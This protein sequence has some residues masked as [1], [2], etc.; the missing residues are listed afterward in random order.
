MKLL[1]LRERNRRLQRRERLALHHLRN[2]AGVFLDSL[3]LPGSHLVLTW[4]AKYPG[5]GEAATMVATGDA[6]GL[7]SFQLRGFTTIANEF[8]GHYIVLR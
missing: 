4:A 8:L 1:L 7:K 6:K 5:G 3:C 2:H